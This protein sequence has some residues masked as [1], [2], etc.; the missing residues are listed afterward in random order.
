MCMYLG[1]RGGLPKR[2]SS[3][4]CRRAAA[5]TAPKRPQGRERVCEPHR[6]LAF[7]RPTPGP[8]DAPASSGDARQTRDAPT[9][10][11]RAVCCL[12]RARRWRRRE[13]TCRLEEGAPQR[14]E[15]AAARPNVPR[16][17]ASTPPASR[18]GA[19]TSRLS[20]PSTGAAF[21]GAFRADFGA[22][23]CAR[24]SP[25]LCADERRV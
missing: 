6:R 4:E 10:W 19:S 20:V 23:G 17:R 1:W 16:A 2:N 14:S 7:S 13:R 22:V 21:K 12:L 25:S 15:R 8:R 5:S 24:L 3:E 18:G 11:S 9:P